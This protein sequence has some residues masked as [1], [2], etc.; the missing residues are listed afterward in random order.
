M[1]KRA[2]GKPNG[3][4]QHR[5]PVPKLQ[6]A[7]KHSR[8]R[9]TQH[10]VCTGGLGRQGLQRENGPDAGRGVP[11]VREQVAGVPWG[12]SNLQVFCQFMFTVL[13]FFR[14]HY[15]DSSNAA[16][17]ATALEQ[18]RAALPRR[19]PARALPGP[20]PAPLSTSQRRLAPPRPGFGKTTPE[21]EGRR[22]A[23]PGTRRGK[24]GRRATTRPP[25]L[26]VLSLPAAH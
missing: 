16:A 9:W 18:P 19:E 3:T 10:S 5:H 17:T 21:G 15:R 20:R 13:L 1:P 8:W 22:A 25:A 11:L 2:R 26:R 24:A 23:L 7:Q 6:K 12:S 14:F 4:H